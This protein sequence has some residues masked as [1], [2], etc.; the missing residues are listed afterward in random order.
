MTRPR[1]LFTETCRALALAVACLACEPTTCHDACSEEHD[2]CLDEAESFE[3]ER[4]CG[5]LYEECD[6][7]CEGRGN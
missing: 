6:A 5:R 1:A 3:D 7:V 4:E 2:D